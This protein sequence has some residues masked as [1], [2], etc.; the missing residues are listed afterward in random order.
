VKHSRTL[1]GLIAAR[2]DHSAQRLFLRDEAGRTLTFGEYRDAAEEVA[3]GLQ[4]MGIGAGSTVAWQLPTWQEALLLTAALARLGARQVPMLPMLREPSVAFICRQVQADLLVV[5]KLWKGFDHAAMAAAVGAQRPG[6]RVLAIDKGELPRATADTL[7]PAPVDA[8]DE[9]AARW[10]FYTSGTTADPKGALHGDASLIA[11]AFGMVAVL[12]LAADDVVPLVFPF[13]HIGGFVWLVS[14][15]LVGCECLLVE[16]FGADVL[17]YLKRHRVTV[18]GAGATFAQTYLKAQREAPGDPVMP[19]LR[20]VTG[21]GST[22]PPQ[23]H[24][25]VKTELNCAGF[26]S[27]YGLTECPIAVMNTVRDPDDKLAVSEGRALPG[28]RIKIVAA[29]GRRAAPGETGV[30]WLH[31]PHRCLGYVDAALNEGAFDDEGYL[32]SGDIGALDADGWLTVT[33]RAKDIIIR[34]GENIS[35]K[36]V[37]DALYQHPQ[38]ADVAVIGLPDAERGELA[39]AVLELRAGGDAPTLQE[40]AAFGLQKGLLKHETPER[41]ERVERMPRN[42]SG[43]VLKEQLRQR[44]GAAKPA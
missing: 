12:E 6:L 31:G 19:R 36:K 27:G 16:T 23:L 13:T 44:F 10:V 43:K 5:P 30:I 37:E 34:K 15:L 42:P 7:P 41:L 35:A 3:A 9:Q 26:I 32:D 33:G 20:C 8:P 14:H 28:M 11:T 25:D 4:A 38:I 29:D 24:Y 2:A 22:R 1:W 40:L 18:A 17:P 21:G 39:C